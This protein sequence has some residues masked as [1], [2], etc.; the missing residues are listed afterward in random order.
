[1]LEDIVNTLLYFRQ[2]VLRTTLSF[3]GIAVG[4]ASV[5]VITSIGESLYASLAQ[6]VGEGERRLIRVRPEWDYVK[7]EI[8]FQP[9]ESYRTRLV[10]SSEDIEGVFYN[11]SLKAL[12]SSPHTGGKERN[13]TGVEPRWLELKDFKLE[14]GTFFSPAYFKTHRHCA[15]IGG[16]LAQELFPEGNALGK[17]MTVTILSRAS[18][19][20]R[21]LSFPFEIVG[22][23]Q[24]KGSLISGIPSYRVF[25]P[26]EFIS[27]EMG[28]GRVADAV[29]V[30]VRD[31]QVIAAAEKRIREFSDFFSN[32]SGSVSLWSGAGEIKSFRSV[33]SMV[34][35]VLS[36][37]AAVSL[38]VGGINIMNIMVV[39]VTERRREIGLRKA[40]GATCATIVQ[41]FLLEAVLLT[42]AGCVC[43]L[44][45]GMVLSYGLFSVFS[46][47]GITVVFSLS[48]AGM[49]TAFF[50]SLGAG[51]F[52]G[53]KPA[54]QA[55]RLDPI[56][57]L[58]Q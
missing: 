2:R 51:I 58:A 26:R 22:V 41:Q 36:V 5:V 19:A 9:T 46:P 15:V 7:N 38:I 10:Q 24:E 29:E 35:V 11:S 27:L 48:T 40:V 6:S 13:I 1:M 25:V 33:L 23:L 28:A 55:S 16:L 14:Y 56:I 8:M 12:I 4:V 45:L 39:T 17:R 18:G 30:C 44:I 54:L 52:F 47:E 32:K 53:L 20:E 42:L 49:R 57:A 3:L 43:G 37:V 50:M 31:V 34:S 21:A